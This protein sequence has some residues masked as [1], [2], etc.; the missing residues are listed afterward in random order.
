MSFLQFNAY[1]PIASRITLSCDVTTELRA[2]LARI[3]VVP[4]DAS[5][6]HLV[7]DLARDYIDQKLIPITES[8]QAALPVLEA[9]RQSC[10]NTD[11][12]IGLGQLIGWLRQ[13]DVVHPPD[14]QV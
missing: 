9:M 4:S 3:G 14:V 12:A 7:D 6:T 11:A 13:G 1:Q 2:H 8:M 10:A 5:V